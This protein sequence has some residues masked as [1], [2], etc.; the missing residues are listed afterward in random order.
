MITLLPTSHTVHQ[1]GRF[2]L[3]QWWWGIYVS[4]CVD[5]G[6][7]GASGPWCLAIYSTRSTISVGILRASSWDLG[8]HKR[9]HPP[10]S[11]PSGSS[12]QGFF[13][14]LLTF[15]PGSAQFVFLLAMAIDDGGCE[16]YNWAGS[17]LKCFFLSSVGAGVCLVPC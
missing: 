10:P 9:G 3:L 17:P 5:V 11:A 16:M 6:I 7:G 14:F 15:F 2:S 4:V 1:W 8:N 13:R 12:Q